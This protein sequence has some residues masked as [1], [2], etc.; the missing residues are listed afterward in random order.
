MVAAPKASSIYSHSSSVRHASPSI[1]KSAATATSGKPRVKA[2][3][4]PPHYL[5]GSN[6]LVSERSRREKAESALQCT[7][8]SLH[9]VTKELVPQVEQLSQAIKVHLRCIA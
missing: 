4:A 3:A 5:G 7:K 8:L 2:A 1:A 6:N 9:T